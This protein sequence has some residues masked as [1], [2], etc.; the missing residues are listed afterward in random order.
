MFQLKGGIL[1]GWNFSLATKCYE[2]D[3]MNMLKESRSWPGAVVTN[4]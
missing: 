1:R 2:N 4:E 3:I